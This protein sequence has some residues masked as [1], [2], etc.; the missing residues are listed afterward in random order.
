MF[1][2]FY[3][4]LSGLRGRISL[5]TF[6]IIIV[7]IFILSTIYSSQQER[8]LKDSFE[9]EISPFLFPVQ[10]LVSEMDYYG[11]T[12]I[13]LELFHL[14]EEKKV[15]E[16]INNLKQNDSIDLDKIEKLKEQKF[17]D[18]AK[19]NLYENGKEKIITLLKEKANKEIQEKE[20]DNIL[21]LATILAKAKLEQKEDKY[22]IYK[23]RYDDAI[24]NLYNYEE[25][26]KNFFLGLDFNQYR[27]ESIN[28]LRWQRFDTKNLSVVKEHSH[29]NTINW[30]NPLVKEPLN[31]IYNQYKNNEPLIESY[32][33]QFNINNIPYFLII[34]TIYQYPGIYE[35]S[36][37]ILQSLE[38]KDKYQW[39]ILIGKIRKINQNIKNIYQ[40]VKEIENKT[41]NKKLLY[42]DETY[43]LLLKNIK[44]LLVKK[45]DL[46]ENHSYEI[47]KKYNSTYFDYYN[48]KTELISKIK[49]K[50]KQLTTLNIKNTDARIPIIKEINQLKKELTNLEKQKRKWIFDEQLQ[51]VDAYLYLPENI[52]Y[53]KIFLEYNFDPNRYTDYIKSYRVRKFYEHLFRD[54]EN[55]LLSPFEKKYFNKYNYRGFFIQDKEEARDIFIDIHTTDFP[56]LAKTSLIEN[57]AGFTRIITD[58]RKFQN[59]LS[60]EKSRFIDTAIALGIRVLI[61][62]ILI[63]GI[64]ISKIQFIIK[65]ILKIGEGNLNI[66]IPY[67]GKDEIS[68][69]A[70][71]V[72]LMVKGLKEKE[73]LKKELN[74]AE[75]IQK[76]LLPSQY[77]ENMKNHLKIASLYKAMIG[78]G[79][80]YYDF[81]EANQKEMIFTIADVSSHGVGPALIMTLMRSRL[82]SIV[83]QGITD[84]LKIALELNQDLY[85]ETPPEIFITSFIGSYNKENAILRFVSS[86][87]PPAILIR[88]HK[89]NFLPSGGLPLA[90]VG[91]ELYQTVIK[92][93]RLELKS[94]DIFIQYTDGL[95]EAMNQNDELFGQERLEQLLYLNTYKE[96]EEL[97]QT[98]ISKLEEFTGKKILTETEFSELNDDIA[99][100]IFKKT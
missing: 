79:G 19:K 11:D 94:G 9:K 44:N 39:K 91:N 69:L 68:Q 62:S 100:L 20:I 4:F 90:A 10:N 47:L 34:K 72:N 85:N 49:E 59:Q 32:S 60:I 3:S 24:R 89:I 40:K 99:I 50:Q 22:L 51:I 67:K 54:I 66:Q 55:W 45:K 13:K 83:K 14:I 7:F 5:F 17:L 48:K 52:I 36:I 25:K 77:P 84:P 28:T 63:S 6:F 42:K 65:E 26:Q 92:S 53:R 80:D 93:Q 87:H 58:M 1:R 43:R 31:I 46:I 64:L 21:E 12:L 96:P 38:S 27:I 82:H 81:I 75:E 41:E 78:V 33:T 56:I 15:N 71:S 8:V 88:N 97:L 57:T 86:G 23:K 98:I 18:T 35:R 2:K 37:K 76:R 16:Y 73:E 70:E 61:I 95:I 74:A 30:Q 29:I